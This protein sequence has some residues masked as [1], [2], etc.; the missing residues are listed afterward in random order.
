MASRQEQLN[1]ILDRLSTNS[2]NDVSG[3]VA[4][5]SDGILLASQVGADVNAERIAA[6]AA[7]VI[8][9]TKRVS[10]ELKAGSMEEVIIKAAGGLFMVLPAGSQSLLAVNLRQG[11]NLGLIRLEARDAAA[12]ISQ[13]L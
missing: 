3:S 13:I 10:G 1:S 6:I 5:S 12:A 2:G 11:A 8:G 7:T 9:V 4:V